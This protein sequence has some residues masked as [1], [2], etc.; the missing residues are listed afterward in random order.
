MTDNTQEQGAKNA[1]HP[2]ADYTHP[3]EMPIIEHKPNPHSD[4]RG[5][6]VHFT[7]EMLDN[8]N[9]Y[10]IYP[11]TNFYND[12]EEA[13]LDWHNKQIE[14]LLDRLEAQWGETI[15]NTLGKPIRIKFVS[16]DAIQDE[17]NRLNPSKSTPFN[18]L[19][20]VK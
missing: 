13:I 17:R 18:K 4:L 7:S 11:T 12:L 15:D 5:T 19:K 6:I 16:V 3:D 2:E 8:P 1:H 10:G 9:D 20:E 14:E